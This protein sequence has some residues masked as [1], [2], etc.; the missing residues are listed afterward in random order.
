M[1]TQAEELTYQDIL[2]RLDKTYELVYV[3]YR[4]NLDEQPE[5][6][7]QIIQEGCMDALWEKVDDWYADYD[8]GFDLIFESIIN[9]LAHDF[10]ISQEAAKDFFEEYE[11][12][13]KDEI[14][15]RDTSNP[16]RDLLRNT[17]EVVCFIPLNLSIYECWSD[18]ELFK[19][20]VKDIK[21]A[22]GLKMRDHRYDRRIEIMLWQASYGGEL[23]VFFTADAEDLAQSGDVNTVEFRD[24]HIAIVDHFNGSGDDCQLDDHKFRTYFDREKV[25]VDKIIKYNYT[26]SV[27]GM[28]DD[29]CADTIY[30]LSKTRRKN[31]DVVSKIK[32][33]A[34]QDKEYQRIFNAGGCSYGDIDFNRHRNTYYLNEFP[35]GTHC[36]HCGQ[37]WID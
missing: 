31:P 35:C 13:V 23:V 25:F 36:P 29:W 22:V 2:D 14:R 10:E 26:Y 18:E 17:R 20:Q 21:K 15:N 1:K 6:L 27:C 3:D 32:L 33:L 8:E 19:Q 24:P 7:Q 11:D 37:F 4:D 9:S 30:H 5:L 12:D 16:T 28:S 34:D